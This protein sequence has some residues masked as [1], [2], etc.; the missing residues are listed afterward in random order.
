M[1]DETCALEAHVGV[2]L[3]L[4]AFLTAAEKVVL[5][6]SVAGTGTKPLN[7]IYSTRVESRVR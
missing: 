7:Q 6:P 2:C 4:L 5:E 3:C 1:A